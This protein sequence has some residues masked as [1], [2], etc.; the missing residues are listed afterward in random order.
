MFIASR[1]SSFG[2]TL[3]TFALALVAYPVVGRYM[4]A[5]RAARTQDLMMPHQLS[6]TLIFW[7]EGYL[8]PCGSSYDALLGGENIGILKHLHCLPVHLW[9]SWYWL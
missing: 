3:A 7:R 4:R 5:A 8:R 9:H 2:P 6:W 1:L